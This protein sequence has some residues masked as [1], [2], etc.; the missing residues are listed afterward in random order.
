MFFSDINR[1]SKFTEKLQ[2][3]WDKQDSLLVVGLD[4][5]E[6]RM[7]ESILQSKDPI[8]D[9]C[10]GIIDATAE[11][12]CAF[13]PQIAY[14]ASQGAEMTLIQLCHYISSTYPDLPILLDSKRG[15][16][17]TTAEHYAKEAFERYRADAITVNPYLGFD[18]IE[19]Y[20]AW[21]DKGVI[22]LCRTSNQ[23]GSDFQFFESAD[24]VP[25]YLEVAKTVA[26]KWNI[27]GQCSLVVGATF[28][29]EIAKVRA[30]V[31]DEMPLLVPGIGAQGGDIEATVMAGANSKGQGLMINS[32]R[33]ILYASSDTD[34]Q[35]AAAE[36]AR[37]TRDSIND[38]RKKFLATQ[39]TKV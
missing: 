36:E 2:N 6:Q 3:A 17:G 18:S 37:K 32:A 5:D 26:D 31:G 1:M 16:I 30:C 25:L 33:A 39:A 12:A 34:W 24:G 27:S 19:P 20:L 29:E 35:E 21:E 13:K 7:P 4:P 9:F 28:P 8:F 22:I 23:G 15:D 14:F 10:K 38:A 11:F